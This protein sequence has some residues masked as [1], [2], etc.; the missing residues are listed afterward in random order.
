MRSRTRV[1]NVQ[2]VDQVYP[3]SVHIENFTHHQ[4]NSNS[5]TDTT[6]SNGAASV[7]GIPSGNVKGPDRDEAGLK[8]NGT[9]SV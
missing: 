2:T 5:T 6:V 8:Y 9:G 7:Q 4:N 3:V 1:V